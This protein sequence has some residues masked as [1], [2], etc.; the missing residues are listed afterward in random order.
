MTQSGVDDL[1]VAVDRTRNELFRALQLLER[2]ARQEL[3]LKRRFGEHAPTV[4]LVCF[5]FGLL[6]GLRRPHRALP[7]PRRD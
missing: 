4:L 7:E 1:R 6:L 2:R 5:G 3:D